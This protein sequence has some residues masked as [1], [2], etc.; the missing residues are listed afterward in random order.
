MDSSLLHGP[1]T[2]YKGAAKKTQQQSILNRESMELLA[3]QAS[4]VF[5]SLENVDHYTLR[6][7]SKV[8]HHVRAAQNSII[9]C[10]SVLHPT[11]T[12]T[13]AIGHKCGSFTTS[14]LSRQGIEQALEGASRIAALAGEN[15][16]YLPPPRPATPLKVE[17][18]DLATAD[19]GIDA[20]AELVTFVLNESI[21][22]GLSSSLYLTHGA[23]NSCY[24]DS[25]GALYFHQSSDCSYSIT[26][27]TPC[28][29]GSAKQQTRSHTFDS[30]ELQ[31][32][33]LTALEYARRSAKAVEME[34]RPYPVILAPSA[35]ADLVGFMLGSM[36][37]RASDEGRSCFSRVGGGT[38]IGQKLLSPLVNIFSDPTCPD[39]PSR[40][41]SNDGQMV[42]MQHWFESGKLVE[43]IT[44]RYWSH[45]LKNSGEIVEPTPHPSNIIFDGGDNSSRQLFSQA[46]LA[47][48][49]TN[50]WYIRV[51]DP[52]ALLLTGL[53]RN[54]LF[55]VENGR[56][57]SAVKN[58]RFNDSP[59][60]I[61]KEVI[62]LSERQ[63]T[64]G[65]EFD[66][67]PVAAPFAF[68][69]EMNFSSH[70]DAV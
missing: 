2:A 29:Y 9:S 26:A 13:C 52:E 48:Y 18:C 70:S 42:R 59:L 22:E 63:K 55:L 20:S 35:C 31:E 34:A 23:C 62:G 58:F 4:D 7:E 19:M 16:E 5:K 11:L 41:F 44:E 24:A 28:G 38:K 27:R 66:E 46:K 69:A 49:V 65:N 33:S 30:N 67:F 53:T 6:I 1:Y 54:G 17:G 43:L 14:R 15:P 68:C 50:F 37:R 21:K 32:L 47:L 12:A 45:R 8:T 25:A 40:P 39:C 51:V 64:C 61:F 3:E 10:G 36:Q 60:S 57:T 56:I